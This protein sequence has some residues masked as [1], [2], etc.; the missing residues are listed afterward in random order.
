MRLPAITPLGLVCFFFISVDS[1]QVE[2]KCT[3]FWEGSE[4]NTSLRREQ[5]PTKRVHG[6]A[7]GTMTLPVLKTKIPFMEPVTTTARIETRCPE[8]DSNDGPQH[9]EAVISVTPILS[10]PA[11]FAF[12]Q[13]D[14]SVCVSQI[15]EHHG[16]GPWN[17]K[18]TKECIYSISIEGRQ[19][20]MEMHVR[21]NRFIV[22]IPMPIL[23]GEN[24]YIVPLGNSINALVSTLEELNRLT[25]PIT[26]ENIMC[27]IATNLTGGQPFEE[28][29]RESLLHHLREPTLWVLGSLLP[30]DIAALTTNRTA[31]IF[32]GCIFQFPAGTLKGVIRFQNAIIIGCLGIMSQSVMSYGEMVR[33]SGIEIIYQQIIRKYP[34]IYNS[35]FPGIDDGSSMRQKKRQNGRQR[36]RPL[37][38]RKRR[39]FVTARNSCANNMGRLCILCFPKHVHE[40]DLENQRTKRF[41]VRQSAPYCMGRYYNPVSMSVYDFWHTQ[42]VG[43][44]LQVYDSS[45]DDTADT[46]SPLFVRENVENPSTMQDGHGLQ[47]PIL[48]RCKYSSCDG[49]VPHSSHVCDTAEHKARKSPDFPILSTGKRP[50]TCPGTIP[51]GSPFGEQMPVLLDPCTCDNTQPMHTYEAPGKCPYAQARTLDE[52]IAFFLRERNTADYFQYYYNTVVRCGETPCMLRKWIESQTESKDMDDFHKKYQELDE[53]Y[54]FTHVFDD[55]FIEFDQYLIEI[56][57][58]CKQHI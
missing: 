2:K 45:N 42:A 19:Y 35:S 49:W 14:R 32:Y 50:K 33:L 40:V 31:T 22:W 29:S 18:N 26:N 9:S 17:G 30:M 10:D 34:R 12:K 3:D 47:T 11:D 52:E 1:A 56:Y 57:M 6:T 8:H 20:S 43:M 25:Q 58:K 36:T 7:Q 38:Q 4:Q 23:P 41:E 24:S 54:A 48:P 37:N 46:Y 44:A 51:L 13:I 28:F 16:M 39:H 55:T 53:K 27:V 21:S 5:R 15:F